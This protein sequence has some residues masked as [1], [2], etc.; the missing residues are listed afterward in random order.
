MEGISWTDLDLEE[1]RTLAM[2]G[3]GVL[4][5][6]FC[7]PV[8][9]LTLRRIGLVIVARLTPAAEKMLQPRFC[10]SSC[11]RSVNTRPHRRIDEREC[12][13]QPYRRTDLRHRLI[14]RGYCVI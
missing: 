2:L 11:K 14:G 10:T 7:D 1:Q 8:A 12:G 9:L 3:D 6:E 4:P 5:A 13:P